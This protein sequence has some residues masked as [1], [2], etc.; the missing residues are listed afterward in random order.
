MCKQVTYNSSLFFYILEKFFKFICIV[1]LKIRNMICRKM[2]IFVMCSSFF[3]ESQQINNRENERKWKIGRVFYGK[4]LKIT[5]WN[6]H[7]MI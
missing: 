2:T 1:W 6:M 5:S 3:S 7:K 4:N